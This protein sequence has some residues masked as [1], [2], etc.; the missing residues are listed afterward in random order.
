[1]A[2]GLASI[3]R[4]FDGLSVRGRG[5]IRGLVFD[6]PDKA[7]RTTALAFERGLII[8][9]SGARGEVV[10]LLPSLTIDRRLLEEGIDILETCVATV[11]GADREEVEAGPALTEAR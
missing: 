2:R 4:R 6:D 11:Y 1:M 7:A 5:M 8:E 3:A 9:T 10:K